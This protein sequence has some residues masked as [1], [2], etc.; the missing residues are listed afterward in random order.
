MKL[1]GAG[2]NN[3]NPRSMASPFASRTVISAARRGSGSRPIVVS[4]TNRTAEPETR[5]TAMPLGSDPDDKAKIVSVTTQ[6]FRLDS[7][8]G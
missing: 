5:A 2:K 8:F 6:S 4:S 1:P 7:S 3:T